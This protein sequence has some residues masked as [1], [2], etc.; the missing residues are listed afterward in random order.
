MGL[1][2]S[3]KPLTEA[4]DKNSYEWLAGHDPDILSGIEAAIDSGVKP[5]DIKRHV[6]MQTN[7]LE[8]AMRCEQ[9]ARYTVRLARE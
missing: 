6:L 2:Q 9:A 1:S 7:R 3:F 4:L 8:L 5:V